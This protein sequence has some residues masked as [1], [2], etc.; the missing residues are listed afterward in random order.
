MKDIYFWIH[1][2]SISVYHEKWRP[3][4]VVTI[5]SEDP[6]LTSATFELLSHRPSFS[7]NSAPHVFATFSLYLCSIFFS[8]RHY[9]SSDRILAFWTPLFHTRQSCVISRQLFTFISFKKLR[10]S[11]SH[12]F[13][14][15][16]NRL[17]ARGFH[18]YKSFTNYV[19]QKV[20][21]VKFTF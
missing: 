3:W 20:S 10:N 14:G 1:W 8:I 9:E 13:C 19:F 11:F 18:L 5:E 21:F 12:P 2:H 17:F 6:Q 15:L 16:R 4:E 7:S